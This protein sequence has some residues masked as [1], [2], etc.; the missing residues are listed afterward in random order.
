MKFL[1]NHQNF[2]VLDLEKKHC[3]FMKKRWDLR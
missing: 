3:L 2:N 1:F